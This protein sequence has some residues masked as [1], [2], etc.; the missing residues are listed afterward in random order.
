[1]ASFRKR[2]NKW[3]YRII[4]KDLNNKRREKSE[5]GFRTKPEARDAAKREEAKLLYGHDFSRENMTVESYLNYWYEI[6]KAGKG[7]YNTERI[8]SQIIKMC[9]KE[10]GHYKMK[11]LKN[12][13]YQRFINKSGK[14]YNHNTLTRYHTTIKEAFERAVDWD[15]IYK[16]PARKVSI[17]GTS[18]VL[19]ETKFIEEKN[20]EKLIK[21]ANDW[22]EEDYSQ[23]FT[24]TR[25]LYYTGMRI[26]EATA[27]NLD[28]HDYK[29]AQI[30]VDQMMV[31]DQG[32]F[33][34]VTD[35]LKTENSYRTIALDKET[36]ELLYFWSKGQ[37]AWLKRHGIENNDNALFINKN[38]NRITPQF[39]RQRLTALCKL[40]DIDQIS[41]H[42][43][44]HTHTVML[45]ESSAS[46]IVTKDEDSTFLESGLTIKYIANRLGDSVQTISKVYD[47]VSKK[48]DRSNVDKIEKLIDSS[49]TRTLWAV[50]GQDIQKEPENH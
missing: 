36:N 29:K 1:M 43:F 44:R 26:G 2:G 20:I 32:K 17:K 3:E 37:K 4:Y 41:P 34:I 12:A 10:L 38:G 39:Y 6:E 11:D 22:V 5:G 30:R 15:I 40:H 35:V 14:N 27:L 21:A 33:W 50:G 24:F 48:V 49:E 8:V 42:M 46:M 18:R 31:Q 25:L 19:K 28:D 23:L 7:A 47:H 45:V 16:N 9:T 13:D